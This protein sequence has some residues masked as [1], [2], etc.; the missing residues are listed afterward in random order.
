[1]LRQRIHVT[2]TDRLRPDRPHKQDWQNAEDPTSRTMSCS[3]QL[4]VESVNLEIFF[5]HWLI[6]PVCG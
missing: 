5:R 4:F 6:A 1:M 2:H 3:A